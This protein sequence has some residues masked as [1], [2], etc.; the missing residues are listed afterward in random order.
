MA[1]IICKDEAYAITGACFEVYNDNDKGCGFM[2]DVYQ[3]CLEIELARRGIP[4]RPQEELQLTY[5]GR[6]L[7]H[8]YIPDF[9]CFDKIIFEVKAVSNLADEH[10]ASSTTT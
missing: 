8:R 10:L 9:L 5:K 7:K 6:L 1:E 3:E 4:F 2:E